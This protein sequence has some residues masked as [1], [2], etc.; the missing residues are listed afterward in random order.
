MPE[1]TQPLL[2]S[3]AFVVSLS[4]LAWLSRQISIHIQIPV[5][6]AT[7]SHDAPTLAIFLVFLPG[8]FI[9]ESAHWLAARLLGLRTGKFRVWPKRTGKSIGLGSVSV[10]TGG[11]VADSLVGMA[12]LLAGSALIALISHYVFDASRLTA[13]LIDGDWRGSVQAFRQALGQ[14][15]GILWAYLLFTIANSMMP[16][17]SD[18]QPLK[19]VLLYAAAAVGLYLLLGLPLN[20]LAQLVDWSLPVLEYLTS[21]FIFTIVLNALV[22]AALFLIR[23]LGRM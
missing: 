14:P 2:V 6:Y 13:T 3:V 23:K 5:Y 12:P 15:D 20:P 4:A 16:S 1:P 11:P 19:P 18:R 7:R 10:Q 17:A 21:A 9:H 8:V 22:L